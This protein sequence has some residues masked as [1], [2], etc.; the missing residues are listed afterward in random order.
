MRSFRVRLIYAPHTRKLLRLVK[1][2]VQVDGKKHSPKLTFNL[3]RANKLF[4]HDSILHEFLKFFA[5]FVVPNC[6]ILGCGAE[7]AISYGE[8]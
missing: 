4:I 6:I 3:S 1:H 5:V 8:R 2:N 7:G